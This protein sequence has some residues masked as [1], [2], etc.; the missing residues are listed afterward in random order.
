MKKTIVLLALF[1]GAATWTF[2][3]ADGAAVYAEKCAKCHGDKGEG[4]L[5][6]TEK[7]CKVPIEK[8]KLDPIAA[9]ADAD[10]RKT[11]AEGR[12]KMPAYK[13]DRGAHRSQRRQTRFSRPARG[14]LG[15]RRRRHRRRSA[16]RV[17]LSC[18]G[19]AGLRCE[20]GA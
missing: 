13:D 5:K 14:R 8:L 6:A 15:D 3:A 17:L 11:T 1:A 2:A 18:S 9:K 4:N 16:A 20:P 12:D 19:R 10:V 7:L